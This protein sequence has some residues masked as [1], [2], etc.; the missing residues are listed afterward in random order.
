MGFLPGD[1]I[2]KLSISGDVDHI[3]RRSKEVWGDAPIVADFSGAKASSNLPPAYDR[4]IHERLIAIWRFN[5]FRLEKFKGRK[6]ESYGLAIY[7]KVSLLAHSCM[8]SCY[9]KVRA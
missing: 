7:Y 6:F 1:A 9:V 8:P 2:T 4:G 3:C 5:A